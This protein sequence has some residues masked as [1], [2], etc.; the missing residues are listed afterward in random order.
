M[1]TNRNRIGST[2]NRMKREAVL[3]ILAVV[4]KINLCKT[5]LTYRCNSE[6]ALVTIANMKA[7]REMV[8]SIVTEPLSFFILLNTAITNERPLIPSLIPSPLRNLS[9]SE[10]KCFLIKKSA[11]QK[12][13]CKRISTKSR[14]SRYQCA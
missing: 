14:I 5:L 1:T 7:E 4:V 3:P 10:P 9:G 6:S 2:D 8:A 12:I 13:L 11:S